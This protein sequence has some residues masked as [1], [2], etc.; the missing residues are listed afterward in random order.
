MQYTLIIIFPIIIFLINLIFKKKKF[1]SNFTGDQHQKLTANSNVPLSGGI[2]LFFF[3]VS[4]FY[5]NHEALLLFIFGIFFLGLV[6]DIKFI[7]SPKIRFVLQLL[8]VFTF[9]Y[10][11]KLHVGPTRIYFLDYFLNYSFFS[12]FFSVFCL[13]IVING[14]NFIDGLNGLLLGY[15]LIIL[16]ILYKLGI[17][18]EINLELIQ[19]NLLIVLLICLL[20]F[21]ILNQFFMGDSGAY[22]LSLIVSFFLISIYQNHQI[23]SPFFIILLLWYPCFENLFSIIR[24]LNIRNSPMS[25][26]NKHFHQLLFLLIKKKFEL[27]NNYANNYSSFLILLYNLCILTIGAMN[28]FST[29]LQI[30]L[31]LFNIVMYLIIYFKLL[32]TIQVN[33]LL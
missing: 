12:Y 17:F 29:Q 15:Y 20:L 31:I 14:S 2:F 32:N 21:N 16:L 33:K 3:I 26:D 27:N 13:M 19:I 11:F 9:V 22:T 23:F 8:L 4:I 18:T 7:K 24:K 5:Y 25:P 28:I 10:Y 1:L 30:T 6:S